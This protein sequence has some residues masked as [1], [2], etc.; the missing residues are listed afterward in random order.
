MNLK[1][2]TQREY[3]RQGTSTNARWTTRAGVSLKKIIRED[4]GIG[5][6]LLP[7]VRWFRVETQEPDS[8]FGSFNVYR[9]G[10]A[11]LEMIPFTNKKINRYVV[12]Q[13]LRLKEYR[14]K[15]KKFNAIAYWRIAW[16]L[17]RSRSFQVIALNSILSGW[18][19]K[20]PYFQVLKIIDE[21][22]SIV[23]ERK[24]WMDFARVYIPKSN[25]KM[26]PLGCP[27]PAWRIFLHMYTLILQLAINPWIDS[28]QHAYVPGRGVLTAWQQIV[29]LLT[30]GR[31][32]Y[33]FDLKGFFD[34]VNTKAVLDHLY[35]DFAYPYTEQVWAAQL[36]RSTPKL[37]KEELL[38]ETAVHRRRLQHEMFEETIRNRPSFDPF[39]HPSVR[40]AKLRQWE[41]DKIRKN[42]TPGLPQG[43]P[44]SPLLSILPLQYVVDDWTVLYADDG[45]Q[46]VERGSAEPRW[47]PENARYAG[48]ELNKEKS[49]WVLKGGEWQK[50]LTF[51]GITYDGKVFR[52][53]T[54]KGSQLEWTD[55]KRFLNWLAEHW[56]DLIHP[57]RQSAQNVTMR[58]TLE[59]NFREG[60]EEFKQKNPTWEHDFKSRFLGFMFSRLQ[61]G[62]W[63]PDTKLEFTLRYTK[64]SLLDQQLVGFLRRQCIEDRVTLYNA[65]SFACACLYRDRTVRYSLR[66]NRINTIRHVGIRLLRDWRPNKLIRWV[67][68]SKPG[69]R[70]T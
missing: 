11:R 40:K 58:Q 19:K 66:R 68:S 56:R 22:D 1:Q 17:M 4:L 10:P 31:D 54:R 24:T 35:Q 13:F 48:V 39:T 43:A 52:A 33:E 14:R 34:K 55:D 30:K 62:D 21:V 53:N 51:L 12:W 49:G 45:L 60:F 2:E 25:N 20:Y 9:K 70:N 42:L 28:N 61:G 7:D 37:P 41:E 26:R 47:D 64:N 59:T 5:L 50:P 18:Y 3:N 8:L 6:R 36:F 27:T 32:I 46:F 65:S 67:I 44:F 63:N 15:G 16:R 38:D 23:R 57:T 29:T 69:K